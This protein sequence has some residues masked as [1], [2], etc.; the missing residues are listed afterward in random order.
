M[1][2]SFQPMREYMEK[3]HISFY[4]L[5][6][7]GIDAQTL[8]RIRHNKPV[9][10]D[11]LERLCFIMNCQPS[12]WIEYY[13]DDSDAPKYTPSAHKP[14]SFFIWRAMFFMF[15]PN[16]GMLFYFLLS[17]SV[18]RTTHCDD[19]IDTILQIPDSGWY[20][21]FSASTLEWCCLCPAINS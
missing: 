20:G 15:I 17:F 12:D 9:T 5:A 13:R 18:G 14:F 2:I 3:K 19:T 21:R 11:T 1:P 6:N 16:D 7:A 4:R 8:R 10:T